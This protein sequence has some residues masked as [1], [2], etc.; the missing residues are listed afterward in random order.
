[1]LLV[2]GDAATAV[3]VAVPASLAT[4]AVEGLFQLRVMKL[5]IVDSKISSAIVCEGFLI[6]YIDSMI[7]VLDRKVCMLHYAVPNF[8]VLALVINMAPWNIDKLQTVLDK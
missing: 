7:C 3:A 1:M 8:K 4:I 5:Y 6:A 2:R